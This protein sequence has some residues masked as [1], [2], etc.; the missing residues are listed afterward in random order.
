[1]IHFPYTIPVGQLGSGSQLYTDYVSGADTRVHELLGGYGRS[2]PIWEETLGARD[3]ES[4]SDRD[5]WQRLVDQ[6]IVYNNSLGANEEVLDK[7]EQTR[8]GAA[9]F[10]VAGQ[11]PGALGGSLLTLYKI[12]TA[13][14]LAEHVERTYKIPCLP[15]FWMGADDA[16]FH[17]IRD[18]FIVDCDLTPLMTSIDNSAWNVASPVGDLPVEA[19]GH[20][21]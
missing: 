6:L 10:V 18:L 15:L 11:Q 4:L 2:R 1:M 21:W 19:V 9:R 16:D 3:N 12:N 5:S 17:E 7:L 13:I 14:A 8:N 20:L